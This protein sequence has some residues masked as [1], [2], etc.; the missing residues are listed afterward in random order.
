MCHDAKDGPVANPSQG[1]SVNS[2]GRVSQQG[3]GRR[4]HASPSEQHNLI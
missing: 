1:S 2:V 3:A 4:R